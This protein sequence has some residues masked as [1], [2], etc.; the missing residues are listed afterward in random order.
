MQ[1]IKQF[2]FFLKAHPSLCQKQKKET[3]KKKKKPTEEFS[4]LLNSKNIDQ[5]LDSN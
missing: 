3:D 1:V 5:D 4:F 2:N